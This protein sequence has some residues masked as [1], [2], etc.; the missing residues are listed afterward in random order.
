MYG[1]EILLDIEDWEACND[2]FGYRLLPQG[3]DP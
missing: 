3:D 2:R 1:L